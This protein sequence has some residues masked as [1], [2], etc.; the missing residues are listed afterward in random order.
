MAATVIR[1]PIR[2]GMKCSM[3]SQVTCQNSSTCRLQCVLLLVSLYYVQIAD[4]TRRTGQR[5]DSIGRTILQTVAQKN[6]LDWPAETTNVRATA[7]SAGRS[8]AFQ[9]G[10]LT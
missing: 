2:G 8:F 7:R 9:P 4:L 3:S 6:K 10:H 1:P 5:S